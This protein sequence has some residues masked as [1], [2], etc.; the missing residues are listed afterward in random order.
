MGAAAPAR[1][2]GRSPLL[3]VFLTVF[4]DLLGFGIVIPLLPIYSKAF[5]AS[6]LE[7]GLLF[8]CFSGMQFLFAPMWGRLSDRIGR[9][10]VLV[11]GLVG[12]AASY[13]VF[14]RADSMLAL[15]VSRLAAG[16]FGGNISAAQALIADITTDR[17]R[18]KG[19]GLIGAAFGL[20]FTFGPLLGG[21][22]S[23]VE[24][25]ATVLPA[26]PGYVAASLS[27]CAALFGAALLREPARHL[28]G[29]R[30]WGMGQVRRAF[31]DGRTGTLIAL[32]FL[33]VF[34]FS[35]FE[36]MFT[37]YGLALF[38]A[39]FGQTTSIEHASVE[40]IL[41]AAPIAGRY[42][43]GIG[44]LSALIQGGFIRRLVPRYGETRLASVGPLVLGIA[45]GVI[46]GAPTWAIV[47]AGCV[48]MPF[49]F[50]LSNPSVNGL[51]SRAAPASEQGAYMGLN[52]SAASLARVLG[53]PF[54]GALFAILPRLP[55][56][57]AAVVLCGAAG[58]AARYRSR[59]GASFEAS[60]APAP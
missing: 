59:H 14:A 41:R 11:G 4:I 46:G 22:L 34:A 44:I 1:G 57:A 27:L 18:A 33:N 23:H 50:G 42:L 58:L 21:E 17:D 53:P 51:L 43:F 48:L 13:V 28:G 12:T 47:I 25:G 35:C 54:A 9:K 6:E 19:M 37:R 40:D 29:G 8:S 38:P 49:G 26:L 15:Y 39:E 24:Y 56:F 3:F 60:A 45:F 16:F 55:F 36:A 10:P 52:Q 2:G 31:A 5:D 30:A 7:L 20:G 32:N